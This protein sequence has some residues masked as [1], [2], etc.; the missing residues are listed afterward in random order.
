MTTTS[1]SSIAQVDVMD[2]QVGKSHLD[3]YLEEA[4]LS[5]KYHPN[6]DVLQYWKDNEARFPDLSLLACDI[7]S[8]QITIVAFESTFS[9][10]SR[11]LNK[12]RTKLLANNMQALIC[13]KNWLVGF[14]VQGK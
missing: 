12:Y 3:T 7:L 13:T 10:G 9:I 8:I 6:L 5:N 11:V 2:S 4:N 14:D 1:T